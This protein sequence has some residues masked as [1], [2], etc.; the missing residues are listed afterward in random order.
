MTTW[1]AG[2]S[3]PRRS[4]SPTSS[5]STRTSR[6]AG[7]PRRHRPHRSNEVTPRS[8][9]AT[10]RA[11]G[12]LSKRDWAVYWQLYEG[13]CRSLRPPDVLIALSCP[14]VD[15]EEAHRAAGQGDGEGDPGRVPAAAAQALHPVVRRRTTCH[16]STGSTP[17]K[18]DYVEDLVDLI[19]VT[20]K[21]EKALLTRCPPARL[22]DVHEVEH[23][24]PEDLPRPRGGPA[25]NSNWP[26]RP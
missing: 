20:R 13:I 10:S 7:S 11:Q 9:R 26:A 15:G 23:G 14:L 24:P 2:R 8:S 18:L 17:G 12:L 4:F 22:A 3:T 19:E 21:V 25:L 16:R 5:S 6:P 1:H